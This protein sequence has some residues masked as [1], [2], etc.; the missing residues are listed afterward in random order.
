MLMMD[1]ITWNAAWSDPGATA[2]DDVDGNLTT[3]IQ[4]FGVGAGLFSE[5]A[6]LDVIHAYTAAAAVPEMR[7]LLAVPVFAVAPCRQPFQGHLSAA[8]WLTHGCLWAVQVSAVDSTR[9]TAEDRS[10]GF[11]VEYYVQDS[12]GNAAPI[13]R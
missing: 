1:N 6:A 12:S 5:A 4:T 9:P 8:N 10:V 2:T 11:V 13:A 7:W 3:S